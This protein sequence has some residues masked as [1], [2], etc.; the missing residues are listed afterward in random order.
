MKLERTINRL[1][2]EKKGVAPNLS[3]PSTFTDKLQWLKLYDQRPEQIVCVDKYLCRGY[4]AERI[5]NS[6][7]LDVYGVSD[8]I[9]HLPFD[10][11]PTVYVLK[12]NHDNGS[13]RVIHNKH[14]LKNARSFLKKR[15]RR[16]FGREKGEWAYAHVK[17]LFFAEQFMPGDVIDYKFHCCSNEVKWVRVIH[18]RTGQSPLEIV[19]DRDYQPMGIPFDPLMRTSNTPPP[20]PA[21]WETMIEA[22][23]TL[24]DGFKFVRV[25]LYELDGKPKFGEMTFWPLAGVLTT[26]HDVF[27]GSLLDF[28]TDIKKTPMH[29]DLSFSSYPKKGLK[30]MAAKLGYRMLDYGI[31][32]DA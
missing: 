17:P 16:T 18:E 13:V 31:K 27:F 12:T 10:V 5:G 4:V 8:H 20:R 29:D 22:A 15:A 7:L 25:D 26:E 3:N 6:F 9:D 2:I 23:L 24:A 28:D 1:C 19:V 32:K 30:G 14:D 11:F 21:S